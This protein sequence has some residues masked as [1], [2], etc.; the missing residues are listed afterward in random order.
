MGHLREVSMPVFATWLS[1]HLFV[2]TRS[3]SYQPWG[4][5]PG[6]ETTVASLSSWTRKPCRI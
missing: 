5:L 1:S 3:R 4:K 6:E 2:V